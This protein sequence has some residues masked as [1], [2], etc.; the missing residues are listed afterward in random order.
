MYRAMHHTVP[1]ALAQS[2]DKPLVMVKAQGGVSSV[3]KRLV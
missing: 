2:I 1:E 3:L